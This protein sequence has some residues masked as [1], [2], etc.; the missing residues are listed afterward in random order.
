MT[1]SRL[2]YRL[3]QL[4][5]AMLCAATVMACNKADSEA[6]TTQAAVRVNGDEISVHQIDALL[7]RLPNPSARQAPQARQQVLER[8]IDQQLA[9]QQATSRQLERTPEVLMAIEIAKRDILAKAYLA[10]IANGLDKPSDEDIKTYYDQHPELFSQRRIYA[11][12]EVSLPADKLDLQELQQQVD[13]KP[14]QELLNW[15]KERNIPY[16]ADAPTRAAEL[17]PMEFLPR[18]AALKNGET[19]IVNSPHAITVLHLV[20]SRSAPLDLAQAKNTIAMYLSKQRSAAAIKKELT[21]LRSQA[22]IE[23]QGEFANPAAAID[24][25]RDASAPAPA[26]A[27]SLSTAAPDGV[28]ESGDALGAPATAQVLEQLK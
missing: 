17:I 22:S 26:G 21:Q 12:Q 16:R 3:S 19:L 18:L 28:H 24:A 2:P 13:D 4:T 25:P 10:Q 6:G 1:R 8:L 15:L 20:A 14:M 27:A 11:L 7:S 5:L 9:I 23:Y